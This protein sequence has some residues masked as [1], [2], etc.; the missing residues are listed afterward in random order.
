MKTLYRLI[1]VATVCEW[2]YSPGAILIALAIAVMLT[3]GCSS[4]MLKSTVDYRAQLVADKAI[5]AY[6]SRL[7]DR[8]STAME[9]RIRMLIRNEIGNSIIDMLPWGLGSLAGGGWLA[10]M[11]K[12]RKETIMGTAQKS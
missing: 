10:S 4:T 6:D 11:A 7:D 3:A 5:A 12:K 1:N 9:T 8:I 2:V